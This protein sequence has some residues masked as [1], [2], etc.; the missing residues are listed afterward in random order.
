MIYYYTIDEL[1]GV[2]FL[3]ITELTE[4]ALEWMRHK[5]CNEWGLIKIED[6]SKFRESTSTVD[7][8][9]YRKL[10]DFTHQ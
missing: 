6:R 8:Y 2:E 10:A 9:Y 3:C 4:R 7:V 1:D 5:R